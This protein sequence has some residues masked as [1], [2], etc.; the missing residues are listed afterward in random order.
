M[1]NK[2]TSSIALLLL[3][4]TTFATDDF[5]GLDRILQTQGSIHTATCTADSACSPGNCCADYRRINGNTVTNVSK[6]C[7]NTQLN[8]RRVLFGGLNHTWVCIN[9]TNAQ[10]QSG[11]PCTDNAGCS[12]ANTCC[13]SRSFSIWGSSQ[14]VGNTCGTV[15][16]SGL[17]TFQQYNVGASPNNFTANVTYTGRCITVPSTPA[18]TT[19]P[20]TVN[21]LANQAAPASSSA[22]SIR[23]TILALAL[24]FLSL[25]LF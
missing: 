2:I 3:A 10:V 14:A 16:S 19:P 17:T 6:T 20:S 9:Q 5:Q 21:T 15:A 18:P 13:Q 4:S 23:L 8:N 12:A 25:S 24:A 1:F 7:V 11:T 22:D